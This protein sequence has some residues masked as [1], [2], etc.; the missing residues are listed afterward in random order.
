VLWSARNNINYSQTGVL[1]ALELTAAHPKTIL[2]NFFQRGKNSIAEGAVKSPFAYILPGDQ[3]DLTRVAFVVNYLRRQGIEVGEATQE[4]S[5]KEGRFPAGSLVVK[6]NQPFGRL[7]RMLLE[8]QVYQ[9]D[10]KKLDDTAWT[11]GLMIRSKVVGCSDR[12]ILDIAVQ[13]VDRYEPQGFLPSEQAPF[14]AVLDHGSINL[15]TLRY[16]LGKTAVQIAEQTFQ[17]SEGIIPAGSLIVP[18][19]ARLKL[20]ESVEPLGLKAVALKAPPAIPLHGIPLP[21]LAVFST[22]GSTQ[23]VGWVRYALDQSEV[24]YDLIYKEQVR[25]GNL[26]SLYDVIV[27]P[28]QGRRTPQSIVKDIP[29]KGKPLPYTKT[30]EFKYLGD[31]GSSPD[32]RGG[33]GEEGLRELR[34]F[35]EQGGLLITLGLSSQVPVAYGWT[36]GIAVTKPSAKFRAIGP[37]VEAKIESPESSLFYGYYERTIPVRWAVPTL[38]EVSEDSHAKVML[39]FTGRQESL[40]SGEFIG[41]EETADR[42]AVIRMPLGKGHLLMF[43]TNPM[44]R[45]QNLGEYRLL[46]NAIFNFKS[47]D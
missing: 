44:F 17:T 30:T 35:V 34:M 15:A 4:I 38:Y 45:H 27:I 3:P 14:Y 24:V 47:D 33:M 21:R 13:P 26:R 1:C 42:P 11:M 5:V 20:E 12:T 46:F 2:E 31:Y 29:M 40:L 8:R 25:Q 43:V 22:W 9:G 19:P 41:I 7:A 16:R 6:L 39:R 28:N 23:D 37:I 36:P 10:S 18:A 32:I